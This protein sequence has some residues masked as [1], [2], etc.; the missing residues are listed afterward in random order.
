MKR[1][2]KFKEYG[3][4]TSCHELMSFFEHVKGASIIIIVQKEKHKT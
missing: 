1:E 2:A 3:I 4:S